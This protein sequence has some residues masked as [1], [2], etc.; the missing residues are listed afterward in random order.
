MY[1]DENVITHL[2]EQG[3][4]TDTF[5][6][7]PPA[8]K[9]HLADVAIR[10]LGEYGFDGLSVD[11]FCREAS[12]SKGSF[13]QYFPSKTHLLE[14]LI[15]LFDRWLEERTHQI[16]ESIQSQRFTGGLILLFEIL[17]GESF[18]NTEQKQFY[19]FMT[20][21]SAHSAV[22]IE[23]LEVRRHLRDLAGTL[24]RS[25]Q[26]GGEVRR[27]IETGIMARYLTLLL[28]ESFQAGDSRVADD[29][30]ISLLLDGIRR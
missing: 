1:M 3:I 23:G 24:L 21:A 11:Q 4:I 10:L 2:A 15:L 9:Q 13:F 8:K 5:R 27:D 28:E 7:L 12:I 25:G 17:G 29:T 6:R 22:A 18:L 30:R 19:L 20:R 14:A 26:A 16:F